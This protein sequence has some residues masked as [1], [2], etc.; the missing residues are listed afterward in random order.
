MHIVQLLSW[1]RVRTL[2]R[3]PEL[4]RCALRM[5]TRMKQ[6]LIVD[7]EPL[8]VKMVSR[9]L[10]GRGYDVRS[11]TNGSEALE[12][13]RTY[14]P[15]LILLDVKMPDMNGFDLLDRIK[16]VPRLAVKPVVFISAMDD[17][18]ARKVARDL[19]ATDYIVK[20]LDEQDV[21]SMLTRYLPQ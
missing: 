3:E 21:T 17:F 7:D 2:L 9:L 4:Q 13:L 8:W 18:D 20:P 12:A 19:G 14:E 5:T 6:I 15:D 16:K 11:A 10:Q 1:E